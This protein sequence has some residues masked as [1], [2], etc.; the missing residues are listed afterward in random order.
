MSS[1]SR[2]SGRVRIVGSRGCSIMVRRG[3]GDGM[4]GITSKGSGSG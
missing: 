2:G 4:I 3:S 1:K